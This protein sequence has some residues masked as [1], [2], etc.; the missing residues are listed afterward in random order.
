MNCFAC[1]ASTIRGQRGHKPLEFLTAGKLASG[2]QW[3][4]VTHGR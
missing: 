1:M 4:H 2:T 3:R